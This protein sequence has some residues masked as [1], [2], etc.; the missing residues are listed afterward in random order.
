MSD[1]II[2]QCRVNKGKPCVYNKKNHYIIYE[3]DKFTLIT[4][5]KKLLKGIFAVQPIKIKYGI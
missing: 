3:S 4:E 5:D 1:Y 2:E